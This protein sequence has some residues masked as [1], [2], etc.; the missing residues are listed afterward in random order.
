MALGR[1][2]EAVCMETTSPAVG[3][4]PSSPCYFSLDQRPSLLFPAENETKILKS[5]VF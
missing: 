4:S 2:E 3:G 1:R 5:S